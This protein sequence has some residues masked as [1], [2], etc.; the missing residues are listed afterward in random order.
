MDFFFLVFIFHFSPL[1]AHAFSYLLEHMEYFIVAVL[2]S[3]STNS[4]IHVISQAVSVN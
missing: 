3:F 2:M 1:H 4:V